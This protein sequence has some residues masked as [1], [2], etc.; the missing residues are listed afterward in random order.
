[1]KGE[2]VDVLD[3][4]TVRVEFIQDYDREVK[5]MRISGNN[6]RIEVKKDLKGMMVQFDPE[7]EDIYG[8]I[9]CI[10]MG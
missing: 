10:L 7:N 9:I 6:S 2:I 5:I 1:M 4:N 3:E 8:R